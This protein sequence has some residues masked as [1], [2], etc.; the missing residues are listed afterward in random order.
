VRGWPGWWLCEPSGG[1]A[2]PS[3]PRRSATSGAL[4]S[5]S[6]S[7]QARHRRVSVQGHSSPVLA[8]GRSSTGASG[9]RVP[10]ELD[11]ETRGPDVTVTSTFGAPILQLIKRATLF[12]AG[13]ELTGPDGDALMPPRSACSPHCKRAPPWTQHDHQCSA[14]RPPL[15]LISIA[16]DHVGKLWDWRSTATGLQLFSLA[17]APPTGLEPVTLRFPGSPWGRSSPR[18]A[19]TS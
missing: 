11:C 8:Y 13:A 6:S 18:P 14:R 5:A 2:G 9:S 19:W 4:R 15:K 10:T 17:E 3:A 12:L 1:R 7:L 16:G